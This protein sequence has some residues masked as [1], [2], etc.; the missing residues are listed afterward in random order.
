MHIY[1]GSTGKSG[2]ENEGSINAD[3]YTAYT[4]FLEYQW[5]VM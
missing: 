4:Y 1:I 3:T 5:W 2:H